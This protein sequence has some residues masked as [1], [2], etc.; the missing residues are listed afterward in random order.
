MVQTVT[1]PSTLNLADLEKLVQKRLYSEPLQLVPLQIR[2]LLKEQTLTII[3]QHPEPILPYPRMV[4]RALRQMLEDERILNKYQ[5]LIYL[6]LYGEKKPYS[7]HNLNVKSE[8]KISNISNTDANPLEFSFNTKS[9]DWLLNNSD[10]PI[11]NNQNGIKDFSLADFLDTASEELETSR[12]VTYDDSLFNGESVISPDLLGE[13][14]PKFP[15]FAQFDLISDDDTPENS[16]EGDYSEDGSEFYSSSEDFT[17]NNPKKPWGKWLI[18]I[19]STSLGFFFA[20]FYFLTRPCVMGKCEILTQAQTYAQTS[21]QILQGNP[22]GSEIFEAQRQLEEAIA[23]L[24]NIP[25]WSIFHKEA[26]VLLSRYQNN[27]QTLDNLILALKTASQASDKAQNPPFTVEKWQE[28]QQDW[29][30]AIARLETIK[31][32]SE[33]YLF[34]QNKIVEYKEKLNVINNRLNQEAKA[35]EKF[36]VAQETIKIAQVRQGTAQSLDNWQLV[37]AT[38][39]TAIERLKEIPPSTTVYEKA[40]ELI[41]DYAL[42]ISE[43]R[44]KKNQELFA[45]NAYN[46]ALRLAQLAQNAESVNQWS[47]AVYHWR[48]ALNYVQQVPQDS[49]QYNQAQP[50]FDS[51]RGALNQ[52]ENKLRRALKLQQASADLSQTCRGIAKVCDFTVGDSVIKVKLTPEYIDDVRQTALKAKAQENTNTQIAL[53][54][55]ISTVET[56]LQVISNNTG[57]R[58]E[59]YEPKGSLAIAYMPK[60]IN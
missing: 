60:N 45:A 56:A 54:D 37:Y 7:F 22:S 59:V 35:V 50:L 4:F 13:K 1:K 41:N 5:V 8:E 6:R 53:L 32:D 39:Q 47:S 27:A 25:Q 46:Q 57:L 55:H 38:W 9:E 58:V 52:S 3:V 24:G 34:A 28:I 49:F 36:N 44:D 15:N 23:L 29:R 16:F 19:L 11:N 48:N 2:C 40:Q 12:E 18:F 51:Y 20:T 42:Q 10:K 33:L 21:N 43:V 31:S 26:E 30:G 17:V 14:P